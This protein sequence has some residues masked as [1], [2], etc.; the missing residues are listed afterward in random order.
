VDDP[1]RPYPCEVANTGEVARI[2][3]DITKGYGLERG[4]ES[5]TK[6][7]EVGI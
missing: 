5:K 1:L 7:E 4:G 6:K 3:H 2:R